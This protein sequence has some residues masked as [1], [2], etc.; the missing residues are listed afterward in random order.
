MPRKRDVL[1][2]KSSVL[3]GRNLS[4]LTHEKIETTPGPLLIPRLYARVYLTGY[5]WRS[6]GCHSDAQA[7]PKKTTCGV[8]GQASRGYYD[9]IVRRA[10]DL[11]SGDRRVYL[12]F[13]V[14]RVQCRRCGTVKRER[15]DWLGDN[16][17]YTK[18]FS[19][20]V[21]RR[22]RVSTVKEVA[23]ELHLDWHTVKEL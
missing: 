5:I 11:S 9:K 10:R 13:E 23:E 8:C 12:E 14:R 6:L 4:R 21:G 19:F 22:C 17:L 2:Q 7:T 3:R 20:F 18:R 16:P 15:L 1:R